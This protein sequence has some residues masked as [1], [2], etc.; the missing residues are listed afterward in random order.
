MQ[1]PSR[2]RRL[3]WLLFAILCG[4]FLLALAVGGWLTWSLPPLQKFY[5]TTYSA[6][7]R[8]ARLPHNLT[9]I[10]WVMKTAPKRKW[11]CCKFL[12]WTEISRGFAFAQT[13][14]GLEVERFSDER[15]GFAERRGTETERSFNDARLAADVAREL[16]A[17]RLAL[18]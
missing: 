16:E 3:F 18:A 17:R 8:G 12:M 2:G 9:T 7:S 1:F 13:S 14:S 5:L 4:P 11:L 15:Y 10:R 6:S